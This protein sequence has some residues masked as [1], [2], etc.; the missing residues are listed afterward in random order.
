MNRSKG[1]LIT[2]SI[3][4]VFI[5]VYGTTLILRLLL[6]N[7]L[8]VGGLMD[9]NYLILALLSSAPF[10]MYLLLK[11]K[12]SVEAS[13]VVFSSGLLFITLFIYVHL[14]LVTMTEEM[15]QGLLL[16]IVTIIPLTAII[17]VFVSHFTLGNK[18]ALNID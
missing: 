5:L 11:G 17:L 18:K 2:S 13:K 1:F 15:T 14:A 8:L 6:G 7:Y 9:P 4:G 16:R 3:A 10:I 12:S